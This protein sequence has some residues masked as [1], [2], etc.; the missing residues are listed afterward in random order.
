MLHETVIGVTAHFGKNR[1][2][3]VSQYTKSLCHS[4]QAEHPLS[5]TTRPCLAKVTNKKQEPQAQCVAAPEL[6]N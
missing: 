6:L 2:K 4:Q 5:C 3:T 1:A